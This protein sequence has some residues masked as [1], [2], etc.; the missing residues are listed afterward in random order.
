[1]SGSFFQIAIIFLAAAVIFV[2]IAKKLGIGSVLGYLIGGIV[3]GPYVLGFVG[4]E[5]ENI[6]HASEFGVVMMLF[7]IG[8]ELNPQSFWRMRKNIV[9]LG[10]SQMLGTTILIFPL[11]YFVLW[12][13]F[14]TSLVISLAFSMS[15]TAIVLQTLKEKGLNNSE[16][17]RA[18]FSVLLFQDI[19][20]IPIL[21]ILPLLAINSAEVNNHGEQNEFIKE[22]KTLAGILSILI[23]FLFGR[24]LINPLLRMI[25][26]VRMRELFT[27]MALLIVVSV[28]YL[29]QLVGL[30]PALGTFLA[31]VLLANSEFRHELESDVEP[32]KG[33]LLGFFFTAVGST[34]NFTL[35]AVNPGFILLSV[36]ILVFIKAIVIFIIGKF[37]KMQMDQNILFALILAQVGEFA[38]VLLS[39]SQN[40]QILSGQNT[41]T[42]MAITTVTMALSP[43]LLFINER[44]ID[45]KFGIKENPNPEKKYDEINKHH[46][47]I[48]AGFGHFGSTL[49]RFLRANGKEAT[50]LDSDSDQVELLRKMGFNVYFGDATRVDLLKSAGADQAKVLVCALNSMEDSL[51]LAETAKKHYPHLKIFMRAKHRFEA[52][53]FFD[54]GIDHV[55]RESVHASVYLGVDILKTLGRRAYTSTRK[56]QEF[57]KYD[58]LALVKLSKEFKD[59]ENYILKVRE[60]IALQEKLLSED[61][62]F[63]LH[64]SNEAWDSEKREGS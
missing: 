51:R 55:Y 43:I 27:A 39:A 14:A 62:K 29:M 30:S 47:I 58:E 45:P 31:G 57:I 61:L 13:D 12:F 63:N 33:V 9:G 50:I 1:M 38:F 24:Y 18:S 56:A 32:F 10:L 37:S 35:I 54:K 17:G 6:M 64:F 5:G 7:L 21:A 49:G 59:T 44:F 20:V 41:E 60:E 28:A 26:K 34:I 19:A 16:A 36:L 52:Y 8:L 46:D 2:P 4:H 40:L 48:I 11:L 23:I 53:E 25:A 3:I 42:M 22:Y 15:S